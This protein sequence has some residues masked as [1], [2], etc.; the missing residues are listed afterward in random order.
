MIAELTI[1]TGTRSGALANATIHDFET[2]KEDQRTKMRV[3]LVPAHKRGVA[4][5]APVTMSE[6]MYQQM[7]RY[8]TYILPQF[9]PSRDVPHLFLMSD[10]RPFLHASIY[11]RISEIWTKSGVRR[12]LRV[13]ATNIRKW[14]VTVC[15][16]KKVE[17]AHVDEGA[18]RLAMCHSNKT[19]E[20]FYL[21]EDLTEVAARGTSIIAQCTRGATPPPPQP[22][23]K[24]GTSSI[25]A[26]PTNSPPPEMKLED[27]AEV[28]QPTRSLSLQEKTTVSNVFADIIGSNSKVTLAGIRAE[29]RDSVP[30]RRLLLIPGMDRKVADRVRHCQSTL[31]KSLPEATQEKQEHIREWQENSSSIVTLETLSSSR[32]EWSSRDNEILQA[33]F[34]H[35][36]KCPTKGELH[37]I[38]AESEELQDSF[39]RV[40]QKKKSKREPRLAN[41]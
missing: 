36:T 35:L 33:R 29:I 4:R 27:R 18:L 15:H 22:L 41:P 39:E 3:M 40:Y 9:G 32:R 19:A 7:L 31:P 37:S 1:Q 10:G 11:R 28:R 17:G 8:V 20:T 34:L 2:V 5:P 24:P 26:T 13:T 12:D 25:E 23:E 6:L 21:R 30:L 38:L 16:Q 14:I